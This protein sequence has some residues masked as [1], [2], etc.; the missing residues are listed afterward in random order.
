MPPREVPSTNELEADQLIEQAQKRAQPSAMA[1]L[2]SLLGASTQS[3]RMEEAAELA[4]KAGNLYKI[5]K[6]WSKSG[7]AYRSAASYLLKAEEL[8]EAAAKLVE[9]GKSYRKAVSEPASGDGGEGPADFVTLSVEV[10]MQAVELLKQRGRFHPAAGHLKT[11]AEMYETDAS[12]EAKALEFYE[13]AGDLYAGEDASGLANQCWLKVAT[14]AGQLEQY[15][16][17]IEKFEHVAFGSL[18][19]QLTKYSSKS[20]FLNAGLCHMCFDIVSASKAI[21]RYLEADMSFGQSREYTLLAGMLDAFDQ[22]DQEKFTAVVADYDRM[23]KLDSWKTSILLRIKKQIS[24]EPSL[25]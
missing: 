20:Y 17:A 2:F 15:Q 14:L 18:D 21:S 3:S 19:N 4:S 16:K 9:S 13:L 1:N 25:T 11:I 12:N 8:D 7:L 10:T 5:A 6:K 23:T 24:E 22:G